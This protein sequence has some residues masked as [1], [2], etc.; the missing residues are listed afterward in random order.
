MLSR[1]LRGVLPAA[2][3]TDAN[4]SHP[5]V[6]SRDKLRC[7]I[8]GLVALLL[9]NKNSG[10]PSE[11]Y[12]SIPADVCKQLFFNLCIHGSRKVQLLTGE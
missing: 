7:L 4:Q 11:L 12:Q 1:R 9:S 10:I 8:E 3:E 5:V 6:P 2:C